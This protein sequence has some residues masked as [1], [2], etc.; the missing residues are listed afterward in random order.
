[1]LRAP[2]LLAAVGLLPAIALAP[3]LP[4]AKEAPPGFIDLRP[5][6]NQK[7]KE[8]FNSGRYAGNHLGSLPAGRQT[9]GGVKFHIG[10]SLIQLGSDSFKNKPEK[11]EGIKVG[12]PVARLHFLHATA[13]SAPEG[14]V[15]GKYFVHY[16]DKTRDEIEVVYGKDVVDWWNYPG[17]KAPTRGK[18]AWEGTNKAAE[19]FDAKINL[20]LL[21]WKSPHPKK[22]VV[23]LDYVA[24]SKTGAAP[25]CVAITADNREK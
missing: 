22:R 13:F 1:M 8:D 4:R 21:T 20:F 15:I 14:T 6:G 5:F 24:T 25:F 16:A 23:S 17:R 18:V 9:F 2:C 10:E 19:K 7:L 12:R 3:P 11:V